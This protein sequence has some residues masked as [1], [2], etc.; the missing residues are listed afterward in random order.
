MVEIIWLLE[1]QL[2]DLVCL[3]SNTTKTW[4]IDGACGRVANT[5]WRMQ[6]A[7][8]AMACTETKKIL[9]N[10]MFRVIKNW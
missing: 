10:L 9:L 6:N 2:C 8:V 3:M 7:Y 5:C 4:L 1:N